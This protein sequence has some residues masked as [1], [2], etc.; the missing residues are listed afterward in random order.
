MDYICRRACP[1]DISRSKAVW[2][3]NRKL[4]E[5]GI[6]SALPS[7]LEDLLSREVISLAII[8]TTSSKLPRMLGG[9]SFVDPDYVK[10]A[11][12]SASTLH[13]FMFAAAF[14]GKNPFLTPKQVA[15]ENARGTLNLMNFFGN[16][17]PIDLSDAELA[18]FYTVSNE[19]YRFFHFGYNYR[20][21]WFEAFKA[22][23]V[24]ELQAQGMHIDRQ[25][26]LADG[27]TAT[28]LRLTAEEALADPYRRFCTLFFPPMPRF[29]FS[30][31]E[32]MLIEHALLE[33]S[34]ADA[35]N[36]LHLSVDAL[37]KRWRSIYRKVDTIA[38]EVLFEAESG[39]ARRRTLLH[40]LR[41]HLEELRP[42]RNAERAMK[43]TTCRRRT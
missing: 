43:S 38:P 28:V 32:Q 35:A 5:P 9:I 36:T 37:K 18:N 6:W 25:L 23:H 4:F 21:M 10:E 8:E 40:H 12:T 22:H 1:K 39:A 42:Y 41:Q 16:F 26:L 20:V 31:G 11:H 14:R 30:S 15:I 29:R 13:N 27:D 17:D 3:C 34:D 19:G 2:E 24:V 7:L 33:S